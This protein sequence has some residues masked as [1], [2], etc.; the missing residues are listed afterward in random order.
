VKLKFKVA[1]KLCGLRFEVSGVRRFRTVYQV[2][3]KA[4]QRLLFADNLSLRIRGEGGDVLNRDSQV[5]EAFDVLLTPR[6]LDESEAEG[7]RGAV[8]RDIQR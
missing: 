1:E 3:S 6:F 2:D 8:G 5:H 4:Q 7:S